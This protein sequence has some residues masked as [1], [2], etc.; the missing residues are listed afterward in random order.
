M[1][2]YYNFFSI[3][4]KLAPKPESLL[5]QL[6]VLHQWRSAMSP[7]KRQ[8]RGQRLS[9]DREKWP[10]LWIAPLQHFL[11]PEEINMPIH[12]LLITLFWNSSERRDCWWGNMKG[13]LEN[14]SFH[15]FHRIHFP[16]IS[17][18]L[19]K[20]GSIKQIYL[21]SKYYLSATSRSHSYIK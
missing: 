9:R 16:H 21:S 18:Y 11:F 1:H 15:M 7:I 8:A 2:I 12:C 10:I 19:F 6:S 20:K 14:I 5:F 3:W 17:E 13:K 4:V